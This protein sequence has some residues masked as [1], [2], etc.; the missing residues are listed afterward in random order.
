MTGDLSCGFKKKYFFLVDGIL[1][2]YNFIIVPVV[3]YLKVKGAIALFKVALGHM[4]LLMEVKGRAVA[5]R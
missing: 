2:R 3:I 4:D 1:L 5:L